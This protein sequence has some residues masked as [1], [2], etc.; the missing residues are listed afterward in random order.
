MITK[1]I[2]E[3][4]ITKYEVRVRIPIYHKIKGVQGATPTKD[5]PI[6][7]TCV[8][9][10]ICPNYKVGDIVY[11]TF[12]NNLLQNVVIIGYLYNDKNVESYPD[13]TVNSLNT[14]TKLNVD[15]IEGLPQSN[16]QSDWNETDNTKPSYIKNK[17]E[18][19][20]ALHIGAIAPTNTKQIWI[21]SGN[22][23]TMKI[24]NPETSS[25]IIPRTVGE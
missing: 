3:E 8:M 11:V 1:G 7:H 2:V 18:V 17:P 21:D 20:D 10:G 4:I 12:E 25:W 16:V 5:L 13:M 23:F 19:F 9:F 6:A 24:Y 15:E 14:I 22:S